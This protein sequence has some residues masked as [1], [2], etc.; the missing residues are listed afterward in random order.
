MAGGW[1]LVLGSQ[2]RA[3]GVP[4]VMSGWQ[5]VTSVNDEKSFHLSFFFKIRKAKYFR[6]RMI[7]ILFLHF[8]ISLFLK[9][10][11]NKNPSGNVI[12]LFYLWNN[13]L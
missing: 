11:L 12:S 8:S 7:I 6:A 3:F 10:C 5:V 4:W 9:I 2:R 13:F 1:Q